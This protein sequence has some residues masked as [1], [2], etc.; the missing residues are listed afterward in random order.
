M[1]GKITH[2]FQPSSIHSKN[3][4][5]REPTPDEHFPTTQNMS[6]PYIILEF[7]FEYLTI[8]ELVRAMSVSTGFYDLAVE[9]IRSRILVAV[10]HSTF[11]LNAPTP[12]DDGAAIKM[13]NPGVYSR[14]DGRTEIIFRP[15]INDR[16]SPM[17]LSGV[18]HVSLD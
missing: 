15:S 13:F 17:E 7:S 5:Q 14:S 16:I 11:T 10:L 2:A 6:I 12:F 8:V 9:T 1:G 18:H 4:R 3:P